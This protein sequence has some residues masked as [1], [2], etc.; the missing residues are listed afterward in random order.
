MRRLKKDETIKKLRN[1]VT[2]RNISK[3]FNINKSYIYKQLHKW[4][5]PKYHN[6]RSF[7]FND[8]RDKAERMRAAG[9]SATMAAMLLEKPRSL[10]VRWYYKAPGDPPENQIVTIYLFRR[11]PKE[12]VRRIINAGFTI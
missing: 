12:A 9:I 8:S 11:D 5:A 7:T 4:N 6:G 1:G 2:V 3:D 10:V